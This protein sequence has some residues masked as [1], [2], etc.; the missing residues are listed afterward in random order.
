MTLSAEQAASLEQAVCLIEENG[1]INSYSGFIAGRTEVSVTDGN[2]SV[3]EI[4][5][6]SSQTGQ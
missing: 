6:V 3:V 5:L 1:T 4:F 2:F